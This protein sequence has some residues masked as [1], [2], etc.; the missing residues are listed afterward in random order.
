MSYRD[1][2]GNVYESKMKVLMLKASGGDLKLTSMLALVDKVMKGY[3]HLS[4]TAPALI[5]YFCFWGMYYKMKPWY[6]RE[7]DTNGHRDAGELKREELEL[8]PHIPEECYQPMLEL[9]RR[10][11]PSGIEG[12]SL[13]TLSPKLTIKDW[14]NAGAQFIKE[15]KLSIRKGDLCLL[16]AEKW[17][18]P[19]LEPVFEA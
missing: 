17:V 6:N 19:P 2:K 11:I 12:Q 7:L 15:G 1:S 3:N 9:G 16:I 5:G 14:N 4:K 13:D 8:L 10:K 18:D